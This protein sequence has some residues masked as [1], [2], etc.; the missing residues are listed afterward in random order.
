MIISQFGKGTL[1]KAIPAHLQQQGVQPEKRGQTAWA[2][3]ASPL[4]FTKHEQLVAFCRDMDL[5]F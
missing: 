5:I 4:G 2:D 3:Q 1:Q